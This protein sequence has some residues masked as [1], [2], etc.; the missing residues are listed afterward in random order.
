MGSEVEWCSTA[1]ASRRAGRCTTFATVTGS[2]LRTLLRPAHWGAV[3]QHWRPG[4]QCSL[5]RERA[6]PYSRR[7]SSSSRSNITFLDVSWTSPAKKNS[8]K[9]R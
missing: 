8:S 5:T 1:A 4:L 7:R 3:R 9:M 6:R 2:G